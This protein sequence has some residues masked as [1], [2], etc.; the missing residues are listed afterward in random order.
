MPR[1]NDPVT[2]SMQEFKKT[3]E[4]TAQKPQEQE[5]LIE[6][7]RVRSAFDN[8]SAQQL[9]RSAQKFYIQEVP[10]IGQ[11]TF[12]ITAVVKLKTKL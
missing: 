3:E 1:K 8:G 6:E 9:H 10:H 2:A 12:G 7:L 4:A 5:H 11:K